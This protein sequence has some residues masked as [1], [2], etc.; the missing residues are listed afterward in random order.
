MKKGREKESERDEETFIGLEKTNE[1]EVSRRRPRETGRNKKENDFLKLILFLSVFSNELHQKN[2][3]RQRAREGG[4]GND[5]V[6]ESWKEKAGRGGGSNS[7]GSAGAVS[8]DADNKNNK[9]ASFPS[10]TPAIG[11]AG[12][13]VGVL[14][15]LWAL[16]AR[17]EV[18]AELG[19]GLLSKANPDGGGASLEGRW[20]WAAAALSSNRATWAFAL[21]ASLY[22]VWQAAMLKDATPL[23]R[24]V[25]FFGMAAYLM[26]AGGGGEKEKER[27]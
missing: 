22:S 25:P 10:W 3:R 2:Q 5:L 9:P 12:A 16:Y 24:F 18:A 6:P 21:D 19:A 11:L 17:P 27:E 20:A 13:S 23:E 7:V 15:I 4:P 1:S 8:A 14:S 26:R